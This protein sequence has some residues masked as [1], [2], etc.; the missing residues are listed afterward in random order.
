MPGARTYPAS[1]RRQHL[2]DSIR[3]RVAFYANR[4]A[5]SPKSENVFMRGV[6]HPKTDYSLDDAARQHQ[7][8]E[9][10]TRTQWDEM[11]VAGYMDDQRHGHVAER[12]LHVG[13]PGASPYGNFPPSPLAQNTVPFHHSKP[14]T[15]KPHRLFAY[16][17]SY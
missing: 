15:L 4:S 2:F 12:A 16:G 1:V 7:Y 11:R 14:A 3:E 6:R 8:D 17:F 5:L 10:K 9:S 13:R